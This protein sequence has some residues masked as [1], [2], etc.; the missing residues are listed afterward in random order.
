MDRFLARISSRREKAGH[1]FYRGYLPFLS[2]IDEPWDLQFFTKVPSIFFGFRFPISRAGRKVI[3]YD[4]FVGSIFF[5]LEIF[6]NPKKKGSR[7]YFLF[8]PPFQG[9]FP[10]YASPI[11]FCSIRASTNQSVPRKKGLSYFILPNP[12]FPHFTM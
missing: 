11:T 8:S 6:L 4:H 2:R 7:K 3:F 10:L 1:Q 5:P 9:P 12:T